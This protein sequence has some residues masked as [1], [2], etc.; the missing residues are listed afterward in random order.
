MLAIGRALMTK[1][2]LLLLDDP[3]QGLAP[4]LVKEISGIITAIREDDTTVL[5]VE[6]NVHMALNV[7]DYGYLLEGG[8]VALADTS[9][10]L[11]HREE[12]QH[13]YLGQ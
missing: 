7:A 5:L 4:R 12:V 10:A 13:A 2:P 3:P 11:R 8:R 1:Q 6:Q 9:A